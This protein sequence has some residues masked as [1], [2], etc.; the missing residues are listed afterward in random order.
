MLRHQGKRKISRIGRRGGKTD[1]LAVF[2]LW[3]SYT[4][5]NDPDDANSRPAVVL[6]AAPYENQVKYIFRRI[7]EFI[8]KSQELQASIKVNTRHPEYIEFKN[9]SCIAGF[10]T[11]TKAGAQGASVR[12]QRA[13]WLIVDEM[14]Y[15]TDED[16]IAIAAIAADT[17]TETGIWACSTPTGRRGK[18]WEYCM[19]AQKQPVVPPGVYTGEFWTAFYFPSTILPSWQKEPLKNEREWKSILGEQGYIREILAEFS[20]E[21]KG[22]FDKKHIDRAKYDYQ[23]SD[24]PDSNAMRVIGVDWDKF[25]ATPT[26]LCVE[27]DPGMTSKTGVRGM[28]KILNRVEIPRQEFTLDAAVN[29]IIQ[30]N[31]I[32]RPE[33][34]YVDRGYGEMQVETLHKRGQEASWDRSDPAHGLDKKVVGIHFAATKDI[35]DPVSKEVVK[36]PIKPWMINQVVRL[37]EQDKIAI[38]QHDD[39]VW[40]QL[41]NYRVEKV[42]VSGQPTYTSVSEH[43]VDALALCALAIADHYPELMNALGPPVLETKVVIAPPIATPQMKLRRG[44]SN[45]DE[46]EYDGPDMQQWYR[47]DDPRDSILYRMRTGQPLRS[48]IGRR[49]PSQRFPARGTPHARVRRKSF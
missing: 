39:V 45:D 28:F 4:H 40:K 24:K 17:T 18:F 38:S 2:A 25:Q 43:S 23:Y 9:G 46:Y 3:Y 11:G 21:V 10:T 15:M 31:G 27:Y 42:S 47:V 13:D 49:Y 32:Y 33:W 16:M 41:E 48:V 30:W 6:I 20:T 35:I 5:G 34:I 44:K 22:V 36:K 7:R 37:F 14:D 1:T 12:G 8:S 29:T 19:E 26:L